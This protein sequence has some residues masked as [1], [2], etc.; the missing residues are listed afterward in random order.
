MKKGPRRIT[1]RDIQKADESLVII[2]KA[3]LFKKP[4]VPKLFGAFSHT[5]PILLHNEI[6]GTSQ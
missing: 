4:K 6:P 2:T 3:A 1:S 5:C